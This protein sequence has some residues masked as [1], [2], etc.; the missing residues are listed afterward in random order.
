MVTSLP[1]SVGCDQSDSPLD[2][3]DAPREPDRRAPTIL[4]VDD[5]EPTRQAFER[6]LR[7][8]NFQVV[9]AESGADA[10][11]IANQAPFDVIIVDLKLGDMS[12]VDV[13]RLL[14]D[15]RRR[16]IL[17]SGFLS[18]ETAVAA[19]KGGA[20]DVIE[21]PVHLSQLVMAVASLIDGGDAPAAATP[22]SLAPRAR[23]APRSV[24]ERWVAYVLKACDAESDLKTLS[25]WALQAAVSYTTL[26]ANC[27][28]MQIRPL[29]ARDFMRVLRAIKRAAARRC[30]PAVFLDV[31]DARTV[32]ML[33]LRAGVDL[34]AEASRATISD[35]L[36][37]QHFIA[38]DNEGLHLLRDAITDWQLDVPHE[39]RTSVDGVFAASSRA[40]GRR[41]AE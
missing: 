15:G 11:L 22:A 30:P 31:S 40:D 33:S 25:S 19:M 4:V 36:T 23:F 13:I 27:R 1:R 38:A 9:T 17:I 16:F 37:H 6:A 29:D 32:R 34:D 10:M 12:G 41:A 24:S 28:I 3:L 8:N 39:R 35:L 5:D 18:I 21:K 14:R 20:V 2:S 7:L 26:C